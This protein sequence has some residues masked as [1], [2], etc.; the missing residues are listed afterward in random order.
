M[1]ARIS[2][3]PKICHGQ[4]CITGTRIP[5]HQIVRM[6]A[7]V[8]GMGG[9][10]VASAF[11]PDG[12]RLAVSAADGPGEGWDVKAGKRTLVVRFG[13]AAEREEFLQQVERER[14]RAAKELAE[15]EESMKAEE[16][17]GVNVK[18][19]ARKEIDLKRKSAR[20]GTERA[21][22]KASILLVRRS[23]LKKKKKSR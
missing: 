1:N 14:E 6:F 10:V 9:M 12:D 20:I 17:N 21:L 4:A 18:E 3:N 5:A 13:T 8:I 23:R 15:I 2:I 11:S 19:G 22:A 7:E 16:G